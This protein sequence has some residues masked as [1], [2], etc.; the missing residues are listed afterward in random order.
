MRFTS[1]AVA[2]VALLSFLMGATFGVIMM[3]LDLQL[4]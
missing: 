1:G 3:L 2:M 4:R